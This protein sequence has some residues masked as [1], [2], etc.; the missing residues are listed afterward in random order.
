M[1][2]KLITRKDDQTKIIRKRSCTSPQA[3]LCII[4]GYIAFA[5]VT[6]LRSFK[7]RTN[8]YPFNG[9]N[10]VFWN[11]TQK[12]NLGENGG[13]RGAQKVELGLG[14]SQHLRHTDNSK[15]NSDVGGDKNIS[16]NILTINSASSI[17]SRNTD[18]EDINEKE[19]VPV[20]AHAPSPSSSP[21]AYLWII[22]AIHEDK[23]SYKGFLWDVLISANILR[24]LGS[25]ADFWLYARLSPDSKLD[26]FPTE[27]L[28]VLS[29]LGV[30][31]KQLPTPEHESFGQVVYDKFLTFNMTDYKRVM[32]LDADTIPLTNLDYY[33]HLSDP[34]YKDLPTILKPNFIV[35][36]M[37]EPCNT[38]MFFVEP[39]AQA[40]R[41]YQDAVHRQHERAK[42]LP[43]PH[44]D[45]M[46]GWGHNFIDSHDYWEAVT[47]KR[48]HWR[49]HASH[50]DQGL[51]YYMV[52]YVRKDVSIAIGDRIQNWKEVDGEEM[53]SK[54]FDIPGVLAKYQAELLK[55]QYFCD[56]PRVKS[57][58]KW[59]CTPP[60]NSVAHFMGKEKPWQGS[61]DI[62]DRDKTFSSRM[63]AAPKSL[64]FKELY[65][66]NE[67]HD[68]G[69]D[70][71]N[72]NSKYLQQMKTSTLG[73]MSYYDDAFNATKALLDTK[74]TVV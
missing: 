51:M 57:I 31:V 53:P 12:R 42:T 30:R 25:K 26:S 49:F 29:A 20:P 16:I 13:I 8:L 56:G 41:Q 37:G 50:S 11:A 2:K 4:I 40:F 27:D 6:N 60:Y 69:L 33:F 68:M 46:D 18:D 19:H 48:R 14:A 54:E 59:R 72:W 61:F 67:K 22:G 24:K 34:G 1:R 43:H 66:L 65:E 62:K 47:M 17:N 35:A 36:S 3:I 73:Y 7:S 52:K 38:G 44:F 21:Y 5:L 32:F 28:R 39:S 23:P 74:K 64:W 63:Q 10:G 9:L 55:H 15:N 71:A 70:L 45:L 58:H